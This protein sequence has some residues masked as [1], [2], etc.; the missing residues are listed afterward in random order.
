M[1]NYED[2][3]VT[4]TCHFVLLSGDRQDD[5]DY[6]LHDVICV[7]II[8]VCV[9]EDI[10]VVCLHKMSYSFSGDALLNKKIELYFVAG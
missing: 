6:G 4:V 7:P 2:F 5:D 3:S 10:D 9:S 8:V 1:G